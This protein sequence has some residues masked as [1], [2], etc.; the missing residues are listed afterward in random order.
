MSSPGLASLLL[1]IDAFDTSTHQVMGRRVAGSSFAQG[2]TASL[3][4]GD[5][6]SLFTGSREALPALQA[7]LQPALVQGA[8]IQLRA[9]LDPTIIARSGCLHI[10]D[11]GLHQWCWLRA[12]GASSRFSL[13]GVTHT[14]CSHR[15]M[16]GLERLVTAPLEP[17]DA[18]V[19]TSRSA[20]Q[21]VQQAMAC[22]HERLE[23]RFQQTLP[24]T[25]APQLPLIP[26]GIDP[27][28]FHWGGR[29]ASRQEQRLQARQQLGLSPSARVVLFLGRLSF[30]SKAHPLPLYRAL[31]R[32]SSKHELVLL[33]CGHIFN[34]D[35][36][37]AYDELA[38]RFPQLRLRRLGGLTAASDQ[39]KKLGLAA[40][41]LFCSP[42]DN[43]QETFGLSVLEAMAS[44]L[45][46]VASDW[47]GY[48][49][50][51]VHGSTGWLVPCRDMLQVQLQP[52]G[53]DRCFS[54]GLQDYDSTVG[55][56]SLGVVLDHAALEK[57]LDDLLAAPERCTA[58]GEAG[59]KR[60]ESVFA[61]RVVSEQ[62]RELWS[63]LSER[64]ASARLEGNRHPWPMAH[65]ARLFAAHASAPPSAGPWWLAEQ[66]SDPNLLTDTMQ[67]CFLQQLIPI[68]SLAS[69]AKKLKA[70]R[71]EGQQW[72]NIHELEQLYGHC[73]I[74]SQQWRRLTN[75]LEKL[76]ILTA[77]HP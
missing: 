22:M 11:P 57:A 56:R 35:I 68:G 3:K 63:E 10:P 61:W 16:Q 4:P 75:L 65:A 15:V 6:L 59:L 13:T 32:L 43:L 18:L 2:M 66:G 45:P 31:D 25:P 19:C 74:P 77:A 24:P 69:L 17:W 1:P 26:L 37:A 38:Q 7:L 62:Y 9:D 53:L 34:P 60:V 23:R 76:A 49:D 44:S 12:D 27:E 41:D 36:A 21:V 73:G 50:L 29:F 20:L 58:M 46:V 40:A 71:Q 33:E 48:R 72:L 14:L 54:L 70:K 39:E 51:V 47:N 67:T 28:P 5:Q 42:A 30:H 55:L 52:D 64:R 8:Q